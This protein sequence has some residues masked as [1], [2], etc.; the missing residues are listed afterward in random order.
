[1][2]AKEINMQFPFIQSKNYLIMPADMCYHVTIRSQVSLL[3]NNGI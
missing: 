2:T 1:M 3:L